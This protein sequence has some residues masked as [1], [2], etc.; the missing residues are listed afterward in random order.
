MNLVVPVNLIAWC[1]WLDWYRGLWAQQGRIPG[2][3]KHWCS[4]NGQ[5]D[6]P[7]TSYSRQSRRWEVG[8]TYF[9]VL[10]E[11]Y[12]FS[13]NTLI[14]WGYFKISTDS[15]SELSHKRS[16]WWWGQITKDFIIFWKLFLWK[17]RNITEDSFRILTKKKFN[18]T[19]LNLISLL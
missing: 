17:I 1:I 7:G 8:K 4:R 11:K 9:G 6:G 18:S 2:L 12:L 19:L 3:D 5:S 14:C 10:I 15:G 13:D 16:T